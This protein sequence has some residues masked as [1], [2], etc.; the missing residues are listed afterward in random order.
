MMPAMVTRFQ[1]VR[2]SLDPFQYVD[3]KD[4]STMW[5]LGLNIGKVFQTLD[6]RNTF[7]PCHYF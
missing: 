2:Y 5:C 4:L 6:Y 7:E 1:A 3:F